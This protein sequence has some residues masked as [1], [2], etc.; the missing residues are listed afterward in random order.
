M[1]DAYK[2]FGYDFE[3]AEQAAENWSNRL[4]ERDQKLDSLKNK[5]YTEVETKERLV[6]RLNRRI[7][8]VKETLQS[9]APQ[10]EVMSDRLRELVEREKPI[11]EEELTNITYE[12]VMGE[13]RDFLSITFFEKGAR[14][15]RSIGR[16][17]TEFENGQVAYG[18]GFMVT[19]RLLIT[20]HHVLSSREDA[21]KSVV[22]FNFQP[23]LSDSK[24]SP[25]TF[26]LDPEK[27]FLNDKRLD[28]A[29]VAVKEH[30][31]GGKSLSDY[32]YCPL[33]KKQGKIAV[34]EC[35]NI[36]QH[37]RGRMK[38]IVIRENKLVDIDMPADL[39][40]LA[41]YM[42]DTEPGSSGS[43]A[44]NDEWEVIALHH[45]SVPKQNEKGEYL[46][47]DGRVWR[48][49]DPPERLAW[50]ANEG[51]RIS[52]IVDFIQKAEI[53][54]HEK[55]LREELLSVPE[56]DAPQPVSPVEESEN[57]REKPS[58]DL[59]MDANK[60]IEQF[61]V[62]ML[63][64]TIT[65]TGPVNITINLGA[66]N[67]THKSAKDE[68]NKTRVS[69]SAETPAAEFQ[70]SI[71]PD[72]DY[73]NRPGYDPDFLGF[74]VPLPKLGTKARK[75]A[76]T[77]QNN[78]G[79]PYEL[80]YYHYS[81]IMNQ[82]RQLAFVSAVNFNANAKF[83]H[84][85]EGGDKWFYDPRIPKQ[86]Q[87]GESLYASNPYDRGHLT[88]RADGAWGET[89]EEAKLA[90]D[91][92]FHFTNCSPQHEVFN[93]STKADKRGVLLWGN[94]EEHIAEQ[95]RANKKKLVVF[96]GPVFRSDDPFHRGV[97]VPREYWKVV[98]CE[99]DNGKPVALA[100]KL[101]Q[102]SLVKEVP[103]EDFK[104]GPYRP[105][106]VKI[107]DLGF[108]TNLNF[109]DLHKHDPL[110]NDSNESFLESDSG[111]ILIKSIE[112]IVY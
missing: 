74:S 3:V 33:V 111:T 104:I 29:L 36:I 9:S 51:I 99:N 83:R 13:T 107:S 81:V 91:D 84:K 88:R 49:G 8:K 58:G 57:S 80:K 92:T 1:N 47:V 28:F 21:A 73:N 16:I 6:K 93:Q 45:S 65:F 53:K 89:E 46:D 26:K 110:E 44:F 85:R 14:A 32:G 19:P 63:S 100:F 112:N 48:R 25:R 94:I 52:H 64:E 71:Q 67:G 61:P 17:V 66:A 23:S 98:V 35:V 86:Y 87:A 76:F 5:K 30:P 78:G 7:E 56:S 10:L 15:S 22:E 109:G 77:G 102:E 18:T 96:N 20:N 54:E 55:P 43:A 60:V 50:Q 69:D 34:G 39:S 24:A 2:E 70:E 41:H 75:E 42:G 68:A 105:Y 103:E 97:R 101:S 62:N 79:S 72:K 38:Q 31:N 37:P 11:T 27:F 90:N 59:E 82:I 40:H 4:K 12:R 106:Q 108:L 95:G